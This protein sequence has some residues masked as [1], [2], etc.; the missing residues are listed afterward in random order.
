MDNQ[1]FISY[2]RTNRETAEKMYGDLISAGYPVWMDRDMKE[3]EA[4][5]KAAEQCPDAKKLIINAY[6]DS[7][8]V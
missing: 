5:V 7:I 2:S 6:S 1:V 3:A 4:Q 8:H